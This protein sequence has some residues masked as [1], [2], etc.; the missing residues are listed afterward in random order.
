MLK[1]VK[2]EHREAKILWSLAAVLFLIL[3]V[4][5]TWKADKFLPQAKAVDEEVVFT[6][7]LYKGVH[8]GQRDCDHWVPFTG[9]WVMIRIQYKRDSEGGLG[10][11]L[12]VEFKTAQADS[13]GWYAPVKALP[14]DRFDVYA[15]IYKVNDVRC[16]N[17]AAWCPSSTGNGWTYWNDPSGNDDAPE[18]EWDTIIYFNW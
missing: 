3:G 10:Y 6:G 5:V 8:E 12:H 11:P 2:L 18:P 1:Y 4:A 16:D 13:G 14:S 9:A 15:E 7:L 17:G